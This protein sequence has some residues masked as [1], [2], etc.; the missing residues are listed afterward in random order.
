MAV[1]STGQTSRKIGFDASKLSKEKALSLLDNAREA[2]VR[3]RKKIK[4][5]TLKEVP[6]EISDFLDGKVA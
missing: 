2:R 6:A 1:D 5:G 3:V 4:N